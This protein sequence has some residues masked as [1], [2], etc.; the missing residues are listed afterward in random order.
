V[1]SAWLACALA[2]SC[3][4]ARTT[5]LV[6]IAAGPSVTLKSL[7]IDIKLGGGGEATRALPPSGGTPQLPAS[8]LVILPDTAEK[9]LVALSAT[10]VGDAPLSAEMLTESD[11]HHEVSLSLTLAPGELPDEGFPDG[12]LPD[13]PSMDLP[14]VLETFTTL[15]VVAGQS[16]GAGEAD[17]T[18]NDTR[19]TAPEGMALVGNTLY[20]A[21]GPGTLRALDITNNQLS[22]IPM[23]NGGSY[24]TF[25]AP[26]EM[27]ADPATGDL[28]V[29][30]T[31]EHLVVKVHVSSGV[32]DATFVA[33]KRYIDGFADGQP[34]TGELSGPRGVAVDGNG[35]L[36]I[37]D[38][39]NDTVRQV[40]L[41]T[42]EMTTAAGTA[43]MTG[44]TDAPG[45]AA[46]FFRPNGLAVQGGDLYVT[47]GTE[48]GAANLGLRKIS[49]ASPSPYPVS[50]VVGTPGGSTISDGPVAMAGIGCGLGLAFQS[51]WYVVDGYRSN[52]RNVV[53]GGSVNT[54]AGDP[55]G[56]SGSG[57]GNG[58][59]ATFHD[60]RWIALDAT[61]AW[62][63]EA[64]ENVLRR[65]VLATPNAVTTPIGALEHAQTKDGT[66]AGALMNQ[67]WA[68]APAGSNTAYF[69]ELGDNVIRKVD[70]T[71]GAVTT[72][73]GGGPGVSSDGDGNSASFSYPSGISVDDQGN[74]WVT[75]RSSSVLR[76]VTFSAGI[77]HVTTVAGMRNV[78]DN[79]D[80]VGAAARF[81]APFG[82]AFDGA[83]T[84][85]V[86]DHDQH[87][88]RAYD[89]NTHMVSTVFG[90]PTKSGFTN[91]S[92][93]TAQL[94]TPA[95]LAYDRA[96]GKLYIVEEQCD[97]RG[98]T[99]NPVTVAL[100]A[101]GGCGYADGAVAG[102]RFSGLEAA[103]LDPSGS[104]LFLAD[105][106]NAV[107][108]KIDFGTKMVSTPI[109]TEGQAIVRPGAL[110]AF[111]N[112]PAGLA[113]TA[114][115]LA[116]SSYAENVILLA[117]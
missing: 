8:V 18:G 40:V 90:T 63:S 83:R 46:R 4:P 105:Y 48:S 100:V 108:R 65:V 20:I 7:S 43:G 87:T 9:V 22:S 28:Y 114:S 91:G 84:V 25:N 53:L 36:W 117:H 95:G 77:A 102:A 35:N 112:S 72:I 82:V 47:D 16:G 92:A 42:Q 39:G 41:A 24:Y 116:I 49:I 45:S 11:P 60:P 94:A 19:L 38:T 34:G 79:V 52:L 26:Q 99:F 103:A 109:G 113:L 96:A 62:I 75:D 13:G 67:P 71:S 10:D 23:T 14:F 3:A 54:I 101:G 44:W 81:D 50:S 55:G 76:Q 104:V 68:M 58:I 5:L 78:A 2:L 85:Y 69:C 33:G 57:D 86:S 15:S 27:A 29:A 111:I 73:A 32:G 21:E 74:L 56:A 98:V 115:G 1:R 93:A 30:S 70:L 110:P 106:D 107:V 6:H 51:S 88:L 64:Q 31:N 61:S 12:G 59:N 80:G 17:G 89:I 97:I 66:G 37:A